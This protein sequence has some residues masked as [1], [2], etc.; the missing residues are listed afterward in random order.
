MVLFESV[1][2]FSLV[3]L[4]VVCVVVVFSFVVAVQQMYEQVI[5]GVLLIITHTRFIYLFTM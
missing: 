2:R 1:V 5:F 4:F 3:V